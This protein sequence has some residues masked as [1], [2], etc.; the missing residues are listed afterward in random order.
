MLLKSHVDIYNYFSYAF[1]QVY[2]YFSIVLFAITRL[3]KKRK[4]ELSNLW[5]MA[6]LFRDLHQYKYVLLK[7]SQI[8]LVN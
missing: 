7:S 2:I 5:T 6:M 8:D 1:S 3:S 4:K